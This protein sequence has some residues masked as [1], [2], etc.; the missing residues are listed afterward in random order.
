MKTKISFI[1][2]SLGF[3]GAEISA[4]TTC[5]ESVK[6]GYIVDLVVLRS[7][8]VLEKKL[9]PNVKVINFNKD[10]V[11]KTIFLLIK[12]FNNHGPNIVIS[13]L[14][15]VNIITIIAKL[16][17]FKKINL[18]STVHSPFEYGDYLYYSKI[19]K[20]FLLSLQKFLLPISNKIAPVSEGT[21]ISIENLLS[22]K[23]HYKVNK[24][25]NPIEAVC[26]R[27]K[28]IKN[29]NIDTYRFIY[30]GR[31]VE[32]KG[33]ITLLNAIQKLSTKIKVELFIFGDG[34]QKKI[35]IDKSKKLSIARL[36]KFPGNKLELNDIYNGS[37]CLLLNSKYESFGRVII[38]ALAYNCHVISSNCPVGPNELLDSG[39]FGDLF[40]CDDFERLINLMYDAAINKSIAKKV[41]QNELNKHLQKFEPSKIL[42]SFLVN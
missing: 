5:N 11:R 35:L 27:K 14:D 15:H 37:D 34:P 6:N 31:L 25:Y 32:D 39:K 28:N 10:K 18:I 33:V 23:Y 24:I 30:V 7:L 29:S 4:I 17:C 41:S 2:D 1:V 38:E 36:I 9:S 19:K 20:Y 16:F 21:K 26:T 22:Q 8:G 12:Y 13:Y 42:E 3:G 40:E